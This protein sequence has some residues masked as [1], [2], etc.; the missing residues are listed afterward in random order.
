M[1]FDKNCISITQI[2]VMFGTC[3][4]LAGRCEKTCSSLA[5]TEDLECEC[6]CSAADQLQCSGQAR[7][8]N[9]A[10]CRSVL[11]SAVLQCCSVV[12]V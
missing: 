10:V 2:P 4:I 11:C 5:V 12:Q 3:G 6:G 8:F 9:Q 7:W 1:T